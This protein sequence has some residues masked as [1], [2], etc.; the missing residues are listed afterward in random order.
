MWK[1]ALVTQEFWLE[2]SW[3]STSENLKHYVQLF[4]VL[5]SASHQPH[6]F[7][8]IRLFCRRVEGVLARLL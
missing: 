4:S 6:L 3:F 2:Y 8:S 7:K 1:M 5:K